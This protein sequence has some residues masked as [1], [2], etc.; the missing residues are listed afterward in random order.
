MLYR[1]VGKMSWLGYMDSL[2]LEWPRLLNY[3]AIPYI[4]KLLNNS[5]FNV[6]METVPDAVWWRMFIATGKISITALKCLFCATVQ[7]PY[8]LFSKWESN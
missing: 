2:L 7:N 4:Y 8:N 1:I 5:V 6:K 3:K